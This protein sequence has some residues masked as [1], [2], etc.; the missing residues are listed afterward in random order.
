MGEQK[1]TPGPWEH[2]GNIILQNGRSIALVHRQGEELLANAR[3]MASAPELLEA[4]E[5]LLHKKG[6]FENA[7]ATAN[8]AIA[9][10]KGE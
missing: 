8:A 1:H 9:K 10:A 3:L 6:S 4:L 7:I 2:L 5:G